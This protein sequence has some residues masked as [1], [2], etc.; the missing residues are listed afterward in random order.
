[1]VSTQGR[2]CKLRPIVANNLTQSSSATLIFIDW[3][4]MSWLAA[5]RISAC[6]SVSTKSMITYRFSHFRLKRNK[7]L[8]WLWTWYGG[9]RV[10][11][12]VAKNAKLNL[13]HLHSNLQMA[14]IITQRRRRVA[15]I[16]YFNKECMKQ[17]FTRKISEVLRFFA[18]SASLLMRETSLKFALRW[19]WDTKDA[20]H[21]SIGPTN[22]SWRI[23]PD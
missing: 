16:L 9:A 22:P 10:V 7:P 19:L 4:Q 5:T 3:Q 8:S 21:L 14:S 12:P 23:P 13:R 2:L 17:L 18:M 11:M 20:S 1:M 6:S 15:V